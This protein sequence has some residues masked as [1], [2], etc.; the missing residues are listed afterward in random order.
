MK[1]KQL[2]QNL[3]IEELKQLTGAGLELIG[4]FYDTVT[5]NFNIFKL[6]QLNDEVLDFIGT[7]TMASMAWAQIRD[8]LTESEA[9]ELIE[10]WKERFD[11]EDDELEARL[12]ALLDIVPQVLVLVGNAVQVYDSATSIITQIKTLIGGIRKM[13]TEKA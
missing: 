3:N 8:G 6:L 11:I 9:T 12:E 2:I 5:G 4:E 13:A 1:T 7:L 10:E